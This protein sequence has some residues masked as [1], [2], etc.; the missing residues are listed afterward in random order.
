MGAI[1]HRRSGRTR[2]IRVALAALFACVATLTVAA[3]ASAHPFVLFTDPALDGAVPDSPESVTLVFNEPV[4][5]T[6]RSVIVTDSTGTP[7]RLAPAQTT[8]GDTVITAAVTESLKPGVYQVRWEA[9][10][11]DGHGT[12]GEFR[13]AVGTVITGASPASSAQATDWTAAGSRWL[14]LAGFA[15]AFGGIIGERMTSKIRRSHAGLPRLRSWAHIG[16][17]LGVIAAAAAAA[18]L[19]LDV[20][21]L[22]VLWESPPGRVALADAVGF[23]VALVLLSLRRGQWAVLPLAAVA[24]SEGIGSH[25]AVE[26]PGVGAMLTGVHLAAAGLWTGALLHTG[27]AAAR[28]RSARPAVREVL[29]AYARL[30]VWLF[31][32]V[33]LTGL[34]MALLLVPISDLTSTSYGRSLLV[35]L[36]LVGVVTTLALAGRGA[37]RA[38]RLGRVTNGARIEVAVLVMVLAATALLV[39]TPTPGALAAAPPPPPRG[40]AVPTGGLAGQVGVNVVASEGQVVV[41]LA[42]PTLGNAFEPEDSPEYALSGDIQS[43]SGSRTPVAF[44]RCG[45]SCFV[46]NVDWTDGD[47]VLSLRAGASGWR[48]GEF[49]AL[50]PWPAQPAGDLLARTVRITR[51]QDQ[52][53]I[54]EAVTSDG[55]DG[56]PQAASVTLDAREFLEGEPYGSGVA[57]IAAQVTTKSGATKLLLGFPAAG[58]YAEVTLDGLGR[59]TQE[60]LAAPSHLMQRRFVYEDDN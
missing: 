41:R 59:I 23:A 54:H 5:V 29:L 38:R 4:T 36:A 16:A 52:V 10:G 17:M 35:K 39:S 26:L 13:F 20:G 44:H 56:L 3:P 40:I 57:P 49:A 37:L 45:D 15:V 8:R 11:V 50:I 1:A 60:T 18:L 53:I 32:V 43:D 33:V 58:F 19:V 55:E 31:V 34:T 21:T 28:W 9:T 2:L 22:S 6:A 47:N 30:A 46:A 24:L 42:T 48:G 12:D 14:L 7:V 27:R 51:G 25:S